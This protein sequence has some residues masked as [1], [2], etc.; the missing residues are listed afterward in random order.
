NQDVRTVLPMLAT[1]EE[2]VGNARVR[3]QGSIAGNLCFTE[4]KS[5]V[6]PALIAYGAEVTLASPAE[7]RTVS[8]EDLIQGP[9]WADKESDEL[10][11]DIRVPVP[12]TGT[13]AVYLKYQITERPT[14]GVALVHDP[15]AGTCR[16]AVGAVGE[17]PTLWTGTSPEEI[18][19]AEISELVDPT[20]D[21][22]G[23]ERYK[24]HV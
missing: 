15:Q 17:V 12:G 22:T 10:L 13:R 18:D 8:V 11:V 5:D 2:R 16:L 9:Y 1:V 21:L 24:R 20:P 19:P 14:L 23:S 6:A 3:A 7:R 4:P